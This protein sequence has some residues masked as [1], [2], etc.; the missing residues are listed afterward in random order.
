MK[1]FFKNN[2]DINEF[3]KHYL[4]HFIDFLKKSQTIDLKPLAQELVQAYIN[5]KKII[6]FGN[7]GGAA[8]AAHFC[9]GLSY[10]TRLWDK[11]FRT[12]NISHDGTLLTSLANDHGYENIFYRQL[13]VHLEAGDVVIAFTAS[14]NS[15]NL[16][17]AFEY[18]K[19]KKV[20]TVAF[21]ASNGGELL[22]M[23]D[24][25]LHFEQLSKNQ[26]FAEDAH[27]IFGHMMSYYFELLLKNDGDI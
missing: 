3:N 10:V 9:T 17:K 24:I 19:S 2:N 18:A 20:K 13:Q 6:T 22:K 5:N 27:M 8:N 26:A 25:A 23:A 11:P 4:D 15:P 16:L 14:G 1:S 21:V 12:L 7:G